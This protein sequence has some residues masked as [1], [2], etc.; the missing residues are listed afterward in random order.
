VRGAAAEGVI[1]VASPVV[2]YEQLLNGR[3]VKPVRDGVHGA[4]SYQEF[5][6]RR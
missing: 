2:V 3:P 5:A 4:G 1:A 6:F